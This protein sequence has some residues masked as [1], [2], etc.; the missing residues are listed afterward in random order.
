MENLTVTSPAFENEGIIPN[1]HTGYGADLSPEIRLSRIDGLAK[2]IAVLMDDLDHPVPGYNHWAI[3]N[4]PVTQ[5]IP[6]GI[7]HG[8]A[9]DILPGAVQGRGYGKHRYSGP[10][11]PFNWSHRYR[12]SVFVLD[13]MLELPAK[14]GKR[15]LIKAMSGHILQQGMLLGRYR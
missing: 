7:P 14:S 9:V 8:R 6:A 11:P 5:V 4:I 3:W 13:S 12:F 10:K 1:V 2:S 15:G